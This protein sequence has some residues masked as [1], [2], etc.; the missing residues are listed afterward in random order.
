VVTAAGHFITRA[1]VETAWVEVLGRLRPGGRA[2]GT[3]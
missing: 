1:V 3:R 2:L